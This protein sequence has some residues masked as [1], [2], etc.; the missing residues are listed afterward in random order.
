[1][2]PECC[3]LQHLALSMF[4]IQ[5]SQEGNG[6]PIRQL[7]DISAMTG[8]RPVTDKGGV[9]PLQEFW[10]NSPALVTLPGLKGKLD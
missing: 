6:D 7:H 2:C 10:P 3:Y 1:M 5:G 8:L 9:C 4:V